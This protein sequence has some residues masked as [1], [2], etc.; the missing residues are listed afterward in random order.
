L[1]PNS[2]NKIGTY[3]LILVLRN[4]KFDMDRRRKGVMQDDESGQEPSGYA[5]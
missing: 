5:A 4:G 3:V 2:E 1:P